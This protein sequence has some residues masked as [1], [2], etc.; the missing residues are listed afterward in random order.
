MD[1]YL[2]IARMKAQKAG[3]TGLLTFATDGKHK[4]Q[5]TAPDGSI[6]RFGARGYGDDIQ[7]RLREMEGLEKPGTA[8]QHR[9][10]YHARA[11]KA[12]GNW[13][14]DPYSANALA[15]RILW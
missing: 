3:L 10:A 5:I 4:L 14:R 12:P 7:Y 15:L 6:R 13:R 1:L 2:S 11:T 8:D 9:S